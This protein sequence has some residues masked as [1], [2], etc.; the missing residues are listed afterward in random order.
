MKNKWSRNSNIE[1]GVPEWEQR[2]N[3]EVTEVIQESFPE[4][5]DQFSD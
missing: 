2:K 1:I 4:L 3:K 5:K